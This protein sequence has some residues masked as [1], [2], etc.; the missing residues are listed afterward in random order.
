[1]YGLKESGMIAYKHLVKNLEPFGYCP[2]ENTPGLWWHKTQPTTLTLCVDDFG[3]KYSHKDDEN[4][5]INAIND[6]YKTTIDWES[7]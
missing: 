5:L 2:C 6:N 1:M 3:V 4:H 7:T